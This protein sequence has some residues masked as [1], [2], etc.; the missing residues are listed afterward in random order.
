MLRRIT[1]LGANMVHDDF[2]GG[3]EHRRII[4][5]AEGWQHVGNEIERQHEIGKC[6]KQ[7]RAYS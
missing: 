7:Y 1:M 5:K 2:H 4:G 6:T 3:C